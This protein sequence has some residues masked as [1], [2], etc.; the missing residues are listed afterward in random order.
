M[1]L[2]TEEGKEGGNQAIE[3]FLAG[4]DPDLD[5][6]LAEHDIAAS[7]AHA[8]M[9][10]S[11]GLLTPAEGEALVAELDRLGKAAER[12][13]LHLEPA[14]EDIHTLI[15]R[16]LTEALG[17]IGKKIH[18]GRSRNDQVLVAMRLHAKAAIER[19]TSLGTELIA[20]LESRIDVD[21]TLELP[22]YTHMQQAMPTTFALWAGAYRDALRDDLGLL[23][24]VRHLVDQNPL[25][26]AAGYGSPLPL[27]RDRTTAELQFDRVQE[28]P[29]YCQNSRGKF[30]AALL[31]SLAHIGQSLNRLAGDLLLYTTR[32][33][34]FFRL[35]DLVTTG[36]SIMP[37]K[38]NADGLELVRAR[39]ARLPALLTQL[40]ATTL[41]LPSAYNRDYQ[42][43]KAPYF[44]AIDDIEGCLYVMR[45]TI[46]GLTPI[47]DRIREATDPAIHATHAAYELVRQGMP[48][49]DAYRE[50][51]RRLRA[52][53]SLG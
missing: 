35:P 51:A 27:D 48:F 41:N 8:R 47:P 40:M 30:E 10:R 14:D 15:E 24:A 43:Q 45:E 34:G 36:S 9:L 13:E 19:I 11:V 5:L 28:N 37:Q 46:E 22:G 3:R 53:E 33:F 20:A 44:R 39:T 4:S 52:G 25:G 1:K 38:R 7:K 18:T 32:E 42:E 49:R 50:I 31:F 12:G 21:G 16:L 6:R 2:W 29:I 26:S 17:D 23:A